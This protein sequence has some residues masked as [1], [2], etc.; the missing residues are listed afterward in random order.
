MTEMVTDLRILTEA[1][2]DLHP[3]FCQFV[4]TVFPSAGFERWIDWGEWN[5][6][7]RSYSL[8]AQDRMIANASVT[9]MRLLLD[10]EE[11]RAWQFGAVGVVPEFRGSGYA[12]RVMRAALEPCGED[13]VFL[14]ANPRVLQFYP[15]YGLVPCPQQVFGV[16][17]CCVPAATSAPQLDP[18]DA[19]IRARIHLLAATGVPTSAGF[20]QRDH[21]RI[22]SWYLANGFAT[23][24]RQLREQL[25]VVSHVDGD[26]LHIDDVLADACCDLEAEI[27]RLIDRPISRIRF[28]FTPERW[29]PQARV[30]EPD[31]KAD[32]FVRGFFPPGSHRFPVMART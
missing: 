9:R 28:G 3:A 5:Q 20:G 6:D 7:Y 27:P 31:T 12:D 23:P 8:F 16:D 13:P 14:F 2:Q 19:A 17:F 10:G 24:P 11:R 32:L 26:C 30:V 15:R 18:D 22:L 4:R 25:L 29:W 21:G 1:D